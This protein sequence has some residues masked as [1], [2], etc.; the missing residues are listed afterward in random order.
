MQCAAAGE[1]VVIVSAKSAVSTLRA[2]Q[3]ADIF[4]GQIG[5]FPGGTEAVALDQRIGSLERDEF[6]SKVASKSP[7]LLKAYWS[8]MIFTGRGQPPKEASD[9][10]SVRKMVADNPHLIGYIDKSALDPS[11][12][13]VLVVR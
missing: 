2:D 3:V 9:G 6:Y 11:V 7:P 4:L 13:A 12:K 8:K 10:N 5:R 1:L